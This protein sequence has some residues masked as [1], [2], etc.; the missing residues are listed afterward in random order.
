MAERPG[1]KQGVAP[2]PARKAARPTSVPSAPNVPKSMGAD[3]QIN[4]A[5]SRA[6]AASSPDAIQQMPE[7]AKTR[8][9]RT[10]DL[11]SIF[12]RLSRSALNALG[13]AEGLR[14]AGRIPEIHME[15]LLAGLYRVPNGP[16]RTVIDG[17]GLSETEFLSLIAE[18][19]KTVIPARDQYEVAGLSG[20]P[21][22]S[23]HVRDA[24]LAGRDVA[25]GQDSDRIESRH[26]LG[27]AMTV[28]DCDPVSQLLRLDVANGVALVLD[29]PETDEQPQ[30]DGNVTPPLPAPLTVGAS[31]KTDQPTAHDLLGYTGLVDALSSLLTG[32]STTFPLTIGISAPWGG[33]KSS[34][35]RLLTRR[36][37]EQPK[38]ARWV[39]VYFPAWRYETG[40]QLW[41]AMA[42]ATYDAALK[43]R[44]GFIGRL[45]FRWDLER[46]RGAV[47][48]LVVRAGATIGAGIVGVLLGNE[49]G[50]VAG[51]PPGAVGTVGGIGGFIA[52]AQALWGRMAD[53][54]KRAIESFAE[55]PGVASG[56]GFTPDAAVQVDQLMNLL[57]EKGG[58][59]AIFIDD[60]DRC[61]PRN[62]VRVIEAVNQI[63]VAGADVAARP[64]DASQS[65]GTSGPE[66]EPR[67]LAFVMGMDRQV[68]ARGIEA[69]YHA[70]KA[71]LD[72][73][74][75]PAG[76]DYG[77][78][79]L[80]KII[81][82]WVTLPTPRPDGLEVLLRT[83]AGFPSATGPDNDALI[84]RFKSQMDAA[85]RD[86]PPEDR[87][88]IT[89]AAR[90]VRADADEASRAAATWAGESFLSTFTVGE[91]KESPEVWA[92]MQEG[93]RCL[94]P[95][96]RQVKR[97]NNAFR[98]Q[99]GLAARSFEVTFSPEQLGALARWVAIRLRWGALAH[100]MDDE[101]DLLWALE[102][103]ANPSIPL[104]GADEDRRKRQQART[105]EWFAED[106]FS[107]LPK[108][109]RALEIKQPGQA[110]AELPFDAFLR[111][112]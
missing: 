104:S 41:A 97:F 21:P 94:E 53:P 92:A 34:I 110:I 42:K 32:S 100:A 68:V 103:T 10:D 4:V 3:A 95:N 9:S 49:L 77:L 60:L 57:L 14:I 75:D 70:L 63:F 43:S 35:M 74:G 58:K 37:E 5:Q 89:A 17:I 39:I 99:L 78:A 28:G 54:F 12:R 48:R 38:S 44:D 82:L 22:V 87:A 86:I 80:D 112:A 23:K 105:P 81:Q 102:R 36:L 30:P 85:T 71:R 13:A 56:D 26:L 96:P 76:E 2:K 31:A 61:T 45:R 55:N 111:V 19:A 1:D 84:D 73:E 98:L 20:L 6:E 101:P 8:S 72:A 59:V 109:L 27:G 52:V 16:M 91:T 79:F 11:D 90:R 24:L 18:A 7:L 88:A 66:S 107:E 108:L 67:R 40:E 69:E 83:V 64:G 65:A 51:A 29:R 25:D 33:G 106:T 50:A 15:H 93:A 47:G 46:K 62:L